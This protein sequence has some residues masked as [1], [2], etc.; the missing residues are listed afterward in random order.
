M[1][2]PSEEALRHLADTIDHELPST[3]LAFVTRH[4]GARP[5]DN[6]IITSGNE[7]SVSGFVSVADAA[8]L[9]FEID[10][11]PPKVIPLAA[12]DCGNYFYVEPQ[13]GAV[14]FWD[15]E[16]E[17]SDE[18]VAEDAARFAEMLEPFDVTRIERATGQV[19]SVW[20]DPSFKPEF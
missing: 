12:D 7:I 10:G 16:V 8:T 2:P 4:D 13:T 5:E 20:V 15:H 1:P 17:G 11:F 6:S 3:Y 19:I 14:Y 9:A 18:K